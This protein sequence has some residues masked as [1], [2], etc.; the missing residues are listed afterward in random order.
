MNQWGS[1]NDWTSQRWEGEGMKLVEATNVSTLRGK[2]LVRPRGL[3]PGAEPAFV[4]SVG[5]SARY[6]A[7]MHG[8]MS[9]ADC[10]AGAIGSDGQ[11]EE[12]FPSA[13]KGIH[14]PVNK[15]SGQF[16]VSWERDVPLP[17]TCYLR[18]MVTS[19]AGLGICYHQLHEAFLNGYVFCC[20]SCP[21]CVAGW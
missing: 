12:A 5:A 7:I 4:D 18:L 16:S 14:S 3:S 10:C 11:K 20:V 8:R 6:S 21:G 15:N 1:R 17:S 9:I 13:E 19:C 2:R